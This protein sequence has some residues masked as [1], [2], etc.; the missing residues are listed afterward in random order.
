M[1]GRLSL[2]AGQ[3]I[4][5][6]TLTDFMDSGGSADV[7]LA[8]GPTGTE[9]ALKIL[10]RSKY[11]LRFADEVKVYR[12]L[13][14]RPGI[15]RLIDANIAPQGDARKGKRSWLAMEIGVPV[16][17][18]LGQSPDLLEVV[19]AVKSYAHTFARLA[20]E[21]FY[22]RDV[23]PSNLYRADDS[24]A[25]GDFG[26]ADFPEKAGLTLP[27]DK[28]GPANFLAPE[29]IEHAGNVAS[30][31]ADVYALA[32]TLWALAASRRFPPPGE[33]RRDRPELRLSSYIED[34]RAVKIE[35]LIE[36][37]TNTSPA[38]RDSM[39]EFADELGFWQESGIPAHSRLSEFAREVVILR[40]AATPV[41]KQESDQERLER[42]YREAG[43]QVHLEV[44]QPLIEDMK[45]TGLT[46]GGSVPRPL[47]NWHSED[48]GGGASHP[49]W[50]VQPA[51]GPW[52]VLSVGV[53]HR[54]EPEADLADL[55]IEVL[56]ARMSANEQ[57]NYLRFSEPFTPDSTTLD[58]ATARVR[59]RLND[60]L[61]SI[62]SEYLAIHKTF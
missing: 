43:S 15:L 17:A 22:H 6:W 61:P 50:S 14:G 12:K 62:I 51:E 47:E 1:P 5:G 45:Q 32:K 58:R 42:L 30:G 20:D 27:G 16:V 25:I 3:Q 49:C 11:T 35:R 33:L 40:E 37:C 52:L 18:H 39:R 10:W 28:L 46:I 29:M 23:K 44:L 21:G 56:I 31:P 41:Q 48:Y 59:I 36:R 9:V 60:S 34:P 8:K 53:F 2:K 13:G 26:I 19:K 54:A 57:Y 7:W 38:S 4:D 55:R 24:F